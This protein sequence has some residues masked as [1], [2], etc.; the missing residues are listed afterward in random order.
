MEC[1]KATPSFL[2][3]TSLQFGQNLLAGVVY[4]FS[5]L[6]SLGWLAG[7]AGIIQGLPH[8]AEARVGWQPRTSTFAGAV[9]QNT[10]TWA[11]GI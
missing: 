4:L 7:R 1:L 10:D 9:G 11:P 6:L 3:L 8:G 2:L 5:T